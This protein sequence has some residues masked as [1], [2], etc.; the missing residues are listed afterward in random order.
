MNLNEYIRHNSSLY[1]NKIAIATSTIKMT[2]LELF[3]YCRYFGCALHGLGL[4]KGDR[5]AFLDVNSIELAAGHFAVPACGMVVV[6]LNHRLAKEEL[7]GILEDAGAA[8]LIYSPPF[9]EIVDEIRPMLSS[10]NHFICTRKR[11]EELIL[12]S[13]IEN[14]TQLTFEEPTENDLA[15]L[16]YTSGT[17]GKPKGVQ[18]SHGNVTSTIATLLIETGF[19]SEDIGLMVAPLFHVAGCHIYMAAIARGCTV[20]LL[21]AFDPIK[22]LEAFSNTEATITLLVPAMIGALLNTPGQENFNLSSLRVMV[23]A[24]APMTPELLKKSI[25]RFGNIFMQIYGLTETSVLTR[26]DI[27]DHNEP[28]LLLSC[29]REMIGCR[30]KLVDD[31]GHETRTGEIGQIIAKGDN[32][33]SGYWNAQEETKLSIKNGWFYTGDAAISDE[34][35]YVFLKDRKKDMIV[36]GGENIYPVEVENVLAE[37]PEI[38][39]AAVIGIPDQKWGEVVIAIAHLDKDRKISEEQI[40][41]FCKRKLAGYKCPKKIVFSDLLPRTPSGK[42]KKNVLREPFWKEFERKIH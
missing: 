15:A 14:A 6:P 28:E 20:N 19:R 42:V 39:E 12:S 13:L 35:G 11:G 30:I 32:I 34:R 10:I 31:D 3:E 21:P 8:V 33:T 37:I 16:L 40:I 2:Y 9:G 17:T 29:G 23:Y 36:S 22:T 7:R 4:K 25:D 27:E 41:D 24:G 1:K 5:I 38:L 18:L 26:L